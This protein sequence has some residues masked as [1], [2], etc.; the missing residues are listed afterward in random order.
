MLRIAI[1]DDQKSMRD[2]IYAYVSKWVLN[3]GLDVEIQYF[4]SGE[5]LLCAVQESLHAK[6]PFDLILL[7]MKMGELNGIQTAKRIRLLNPYAYLIF[8]TS[9]FTEVIFDAFEVRAFRYIMKNKMKEELPKALDDVIA[10]MENGR[11]NIIMVTFNKNKMRLII[12]DVQFFE[13]STRMVTAH[14]I[15]GE[16]CRFAMQTG[17]LEELLKGKPFIRCHQSYFV[18]INCIHTIRNYKVFLSDG[19]ELPV[20]RGRYE[21]TKKEFAWSLR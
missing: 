8:V 15:Y 9:H 4:S 5:E 3:R 21:Q 6:D 18:N 7:D 19:R 12:S 13:S 11:E 17:D 10:D 16:E 14:M 1:C 20:S 2:I